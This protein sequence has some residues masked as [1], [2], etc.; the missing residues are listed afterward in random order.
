M[1][2]KTQKILLIEEEIEQARIQT[3]AEVLRFRTI[4]Y[5]AILLGL[6]AILMLCLFQWL[7]LY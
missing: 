2:Q 5:L 4:D 6:G 1:R 7:R 3:R